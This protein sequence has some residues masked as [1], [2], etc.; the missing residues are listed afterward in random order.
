MSQPDCNCDK[1]YRHDRVINYDYRPNPC[2]G[3]LILQA[4]QFSFN[5]ETLS[6][7]TVFHVDTES[8]VS[9]GEEDY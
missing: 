9:N 6:N 4:L 2:S 3:R 1:M 7:K 5:Y 8:V